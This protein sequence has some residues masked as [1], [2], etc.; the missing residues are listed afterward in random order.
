MKDSASEDPKPAEQKW[1]KA[2]KYIEEAEEN[3]G[4]TYHT[5]HPYQTP[6]LLQEISV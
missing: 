1:S 6:I 3:L 4:E 2:A 5:V